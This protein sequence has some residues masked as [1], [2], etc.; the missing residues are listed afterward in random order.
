MYTAKICGPEVEVGLEKCVA[1]IADQDLL[2][3]NTLKYQMTYDPEILSFV[4]IEKFSSKLPSLN[5][6]KF[7]IKNGVVTLDWV[8]KLGTRTINN[9]DTL[10]KV[11]FDVLG[12]GVKVTP[13][14]IINAGAT[15]LYGNFPINYE[16]NATNCAIQIKQPPGVVFTIGNG[17]GKK[18]ETICV[19]VSVSNFNKKDS[20]TFNMSWDPSRLKFVNINVLARMIAR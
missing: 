9:G 11:C 7:T 6:S 15:V 3:V 17:E 8:N 16:L 18:G 2:N 13:L 19:P 20:L 10:Y 5:T 4:R 12:V 1:I 14:K